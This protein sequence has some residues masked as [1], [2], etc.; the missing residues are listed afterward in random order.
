MNKLS[1]GSNM[2]WESSRI[3]I[4]EHREAYLEMIKDNKRKER[5]VL[6]E[7]EIEEITIR[8]T[9][10]LYNDRIVTIKIFD[11]FETIEITGKVI[12]LN[13]NELL[14]DHGKKTWIKYNDIVFVS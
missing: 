4:P 5:P 12:K 3:I 8:L 11:P 2:M 9:E 1:K 13:Q 7:Q 10:S 6:D 14:V